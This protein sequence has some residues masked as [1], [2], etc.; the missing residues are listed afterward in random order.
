MKNE[1]KDP[2][3]KFEEINLLVE[4]IKETVSSYG[5]NRIHLKTVAE[6]KEFNRTNHTPFKIEET[7][8]KVLRPDL[9]PLNAYLVTKNKM[10]TKNQA[11]R[12]FYVGNCFRRTAN[13][14]KVAEIYQVGLEYLNSYSPRADAEVILIA[15]NILNTL[16]LNKWRLKI[17]NADILLDILQEVGLCV[18]HELMDDLKK[19]T[20]L[21][22]EL[23]Y[24]KRFSKCNNNIDLSS[25]LKKLCWILKENFSK[26]LI[27][28]H[29]E[30]ANIEKLTIAEK[31]L[32]DIFY[33]YK[34]KWKD[35]YNIRN[36]FAENLIKLLHAKDEK[37]DELC[38]KLKQLFPHIHN[39]GIDRMNKLYSTLGKR[40]LPEDLQK[41]QLDF[42]LSKE[43]K[44]YTDIVFELYYETPE[45]LK[46]LCVGGRYD[47]LFYE[48]SLSEGKTINDIPATG[49]AIEPDIL[50]PFLSN[51]ILQRTTNI[52]R[53]QNTGFRIMIACNREL[54]DA[55]DK[56]ANKLRQ[57]YSNIV[58]ITDIVDRDEANEIA[59]TRREDHVLFIEMK[60]ELW[61]EEKIN[62]TYIRTGRHWKVTESNL[63]NL[64][65]VLHNV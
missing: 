44:Y 47:T 61:E 16:K 59:K 56:L 46:S 7:D 13:N 48:I 9:T 3:S 4:K 32:N 29:A 54:L 57:K 10:I 50:M 33:H 34:L 5:Y 11:C 25:Y 18:K 52:T 17:G 28:E 1:N 2:I 60:N 42:C 40:L 65:D 64:L 38:L 23:H 43:L 37:F 20:E 45:S 51:E 49:F 36:K 15:I 31:H 41:C 39:A 6:E 53:T 55:A 35:I 21:D 62:V 19:L 27:E 26:E 58:V 30:N 24:F 12:L 22:D 63:F 8:D 14:K